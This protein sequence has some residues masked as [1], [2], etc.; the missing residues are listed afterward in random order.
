MVGLL[1][2]G[3]ELGLSNIISITTGGLTVVNEPVESCTLLAPPSFFLANWPSLSLPFLQLP[4][5]LSE[6]QILPQA[7]L[8]RYFPKDSLLSMENS[9]ISYYDHAFHFVMY[10]Y[11]MYSKLGVLYK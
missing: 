9:G 4:S 8:S 5:F 2:K 10:Y 3:M 6:G 1:T 11:D 7:Y